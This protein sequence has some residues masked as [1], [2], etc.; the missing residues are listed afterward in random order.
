MFYCGMVA[1]TVFK[2]ADIKGV[3]QRA[4]RVQRPLTTGIE[5]RQFLSLRGTTCDVTMGGARETA[6][7]SSTIAPLT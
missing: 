3:R 1:F 7:A 4:S 5:K 2:H 6:L